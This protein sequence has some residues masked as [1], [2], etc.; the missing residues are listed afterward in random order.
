MLM[1]VETEHRIAM[2]MPPV[3]TL[4]VHSIAHVMVDSQEMGHI[5]K[6]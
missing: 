5:V 4:S 1:N 6:V 2:Q 3:I